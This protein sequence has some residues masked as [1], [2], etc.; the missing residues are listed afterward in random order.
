MRKGMR[1]IDARKLPA[2]FLALAVLSAQAGSARAQAAPADPASARRLEGFADFVD[3]QLLKYHVPGASVA[4]VKGNR[5]IY[6][7]GFGK[8]DL[9]RGLP[10]T[11]LTIMPIG[12]STKAF[13]T[14]VIGTL[15]DEGK[16]DWDKPVRSYV[17]D[18][19]MHDP[20]ATE[21]MTLR[22]MACHR[23]GLPRHELS[24]IGSPFTREELF[25]RLQ[26]LE[27]NADFRSRYQYQNLI[28]MAA[29]HIAGKVAGKSWEQLVE[30]RIFRPLGMDSANFSDQTILESDEAAKPYL[31]QNG[32]FEERPAT[33]GEDAVG[34]SGSIC[35]HVLDVAKWVQVHLNNGEYNGRRLVS[36]ATLRLMHTPQVTMEGDDPDPIEQ[37]LSQYRE[38]SV[39]TY[40]FGWN[41]GAYRG[42]RMVEHGGNTDGFTTSLKMLP[43]DGIGVVVLT[44]AD[45]TDAGEV[46]CYNAFDRLLGLDQLDWSGRM[47]KVWQKIL[48]MIAGMKQQAATGRKE[49]TRPSHPLADYAGEYEHP[50]YGTFTIRTEGDRL[51][52]FYN[53]HDWPVTHHHYDVFSFDFWML[54]MGF[55]GTFQYGPDGTIDRLSLPLEPEVKE[56][57]FVRKTNK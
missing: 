11:E 45:H 4:I 21:R 56:I 52:A 2:L 25:E 1:T 10:V 30:E 15:V 53:G 18:F 38:L 17:P 5:V 12:S 37:E 9:G 57:V 19:R 40:A 14:F 43:D 36:E 54:G 16:L 23:S 50:G 49:G 7:R 6:A 42:R 44:N 47:L 13:T 29:G 34:P 48:D 46:I 35:A 33:F 22:D 26:Y 32:A 41:V 55:L 20:F 51:L 39:N 24:W 27:P 8:R 28:Y 3:E 31:F